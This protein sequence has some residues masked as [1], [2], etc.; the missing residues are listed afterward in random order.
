[1][2]HTDSLVMQQAE[3]DP[4]GTYHIPTE[5]QTLYIQRHVWWVKGQAKTF[6]QG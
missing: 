4:L 6:S 5:Y 1:M 3:L 2:L